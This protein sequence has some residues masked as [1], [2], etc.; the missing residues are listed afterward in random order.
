VNN[1][2][3][4]LRQAMHEKRCKSADVAKGT[5]INPSVLSR[6]LSGANKPSSDNIIAISHY[7]NVSPEWLLSSSEASESIQK[8]QVIS[9]ATE[10]LL[11]TIEVQ[12]KLIKNLE[13]EVARLEEKV[14]E[15]E[16]WKATSKERHAK[17]KAKA[18]LAIAKNKNTLRINTSRKR[19]K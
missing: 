7:L 6:Y 15:W 17:G 14:K 12:D 8:S 4:K 11:K 19:K 1:F 10:P 9:S 16:D 13:N 5:G 2:P 18:D 3:E